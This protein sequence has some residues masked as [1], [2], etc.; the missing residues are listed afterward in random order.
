MSSLRTAVLVRVTF[1]LMIVS[2]A[3]ALTSY[4]LAKLEANKFLD[5]Q[6][7]EAAMSAGKKA[8]RKHVQPKHDPDPEDRLVV[9]IWDGADALMLASGP[10]IN[11]PRQPSEGYFDV[12]A[13]GKAW[14]TFRASD[15]RRVVQISQRWSAREEIAARAATGAALP[16]VVAI[17]LAWA[18]IGWSINQIL[19]GLGHLSTEIGTRSVEAKDSL[20]L[21]RVPTE[22]APLIGATNDLIARHQQAIEIQRRFISDAAHELRTPFAALQIQLDNL[23]GRGDV[24]PISEVVAELR[25]GVRRGTQLVS[26][27]LTMARA[28]SS[29]TRERQLVSIG[30][31]IRVVIAD[32]VPIL[33]ENDLTLTVNLKEEIDVKGDRVDLEILLRTLIENSVRYTSSSG[34]IVINAERRNQH[35]MIEIIDSGCGIPETTL[36][37][38]FDRFFRAAPPDIE[39]SGLGLAIAKAIADRNG[40]KLSI[41]NRSDVAGVI[42]LIELSCSGDSLH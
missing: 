33:E 20:S 9:Q 41:R 18:L 34:H 7:A 2:F 1:L 23:L 14:R 29:Q 32:F 26:Q 39:G 24:S 25:D 5:A 37:F 13:D 22:I 8:L 30:D 3:T 35:A 27:L 17:P 36:P 42:A 21:E 40:V 6:L 16:F 28:E 10:K 38:I 19:R 11:I 31:L 12:I 4:L 15:G